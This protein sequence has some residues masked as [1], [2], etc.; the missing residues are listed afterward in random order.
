MR[1]LCIEGIEGTVLGRTRSLRIS[2]SHCD[3]VQDGTKVSTKSAE[4]GSTFLFRRTRRTFR[5]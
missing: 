4:D 1:C 5:S 3:I 2:A